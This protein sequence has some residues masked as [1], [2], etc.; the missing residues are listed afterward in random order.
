[1]IPC[2][3]CGAP[4]HTVVARHAGLW[5][6][7]ITNVVCQACG[8][9]FRQAPWGPQETADFYRLVS[10]YYVDAYGTDRLGEELEGFPE[11]YAR[12]DARRAAWV[13]A[14]APPGGRVL[15]VGAANGCLVSSLQA[16]GFAAEGV[17]LDEDAVADAARRGLPVH[18]VAFE[19][20]DYPDASFAAVTMIDVLEHCADL[21][22]FLRQARRLV[23]DGGL[24]FV[25][26]PDATLVHMLPEHFLVPEHN[27]HF[28]APT[29]RWLLAQEGW[30]A[31]GLEVIP[32]PTHGADG[33]AVVARKVAEG[34]AQ[35]EQPGPEEHDRVVAALQRAR[36]EVRLVASQRLRDMLTRAL[37]PQV[38]AAVYRPILG[39]TLGLKRALGLYREPPA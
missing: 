9:M 18:L 30:R 23:P 17:E 36:R 15:D 16:Q 12:P 3:L 28:T 10:R 1:M 34:E 2:P 25:E 13:A 20:V 37:G 19:D 5:N 29:L 33:M 11:C 38:G 4:A 27:W 8:F 39:A 26:V 22:V 32:E 6:H 14:H 35:A 24:L 31:E 21:R 7:R